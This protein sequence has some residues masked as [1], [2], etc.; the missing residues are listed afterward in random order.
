MSFQL[1]KMPVDLETNI[2]GSKYF[3]WKEAL[4]LP[5]MNAYAV[6][7]RLQQDYI[8]KQA[9]ALDGVREYFGRPIQVHCWL[10]PTKYNE[11][12]GG[13]PQSRH[14][15][16]DATDFTVLG[17]EHE[18]VKKILMGNP[19]IYIGRGEIDTTN[20]IHLDTR[21]QKWFYGRRR[22]EG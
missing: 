12:V 10:R 9:K 4:W 5:Q 22:T 1:P 19:D 8:V 11:L 18:E 7:S 16:G 20:W 6:P 15:L 2:Q 13:A 3:K 14:L 17:M 21:D